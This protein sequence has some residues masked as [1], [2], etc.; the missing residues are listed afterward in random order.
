MAGISGE[1]P[2]E[3]KRRVKRAWDRW[4]EERMPDL[5][6]MVREPHLEFRWR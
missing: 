3:R 4:F 2:V 6:Q 5:R 1:P